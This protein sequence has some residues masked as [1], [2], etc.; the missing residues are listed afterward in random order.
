[1]WCQK[2]ANWSAGREFALDDFGTGYSSLAYLD[3][4]DPGAEVDRSFV[5][6]APTT[7]TTAG[8][9]EAI[10][11]VASQFGFTRVVAE[12]VETQEQVELWPSANPPWSTRATF[13]GTPS[14]WTNGWPDRPQMH[15]GQGP[16]L[17]GVCR[18]PGCCSTGLADLIP[19]Q[20][21]GLYLKAQ[22]AI[23]KVSNKS[24]VGHLSSTV[25]AGDQ[26]ADFKAERGYQCNGSASAL[27]K[28]PAPCFGIRR[29]A[30]RTGVHACPTAAAKRRISR[31]GWRRRWW[32]HRVMSVQRVKAPANVVVP[33]QV[34]IVAECMPVACRIAF[35]HRAPQRGCGIYPPAVVMKRLS[36]AAPG[37]DGSHEATPSAFGRQMQHPGMACVKVAGSGEQP[38]AVVGEGGVVSA[39]R[40]WCP[41][42]PAPRH[43]G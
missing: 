20:C 32:S 2:S 19:N 27:P 43:A 3:A 33:Q 4:A 42:G 13:L 17:S 37:N 18:L 35:H 15:Q 34:P 25:G 9:V 16:A 23:N 1:M 11:T 39:G 6:E 14:P 40:R 36:A 29:S 38:G 24:F 41:P 28:N 22:A 31:C 30:D 10:L 7:R 12:G 26:Q 8:L 21:L 5:S